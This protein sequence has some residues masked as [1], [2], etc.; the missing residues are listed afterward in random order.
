MLVCTENTGQYTFPFGI[1]KPYNASCDSRTPKKSKI[2]KCKKEKNDKIDA[3]CITIYVSRTQDK[4]Q[5]YKRLTKYITLKS[6]YNLYVPQYK[7]QMK[8]QKNCP[9]PNMNAR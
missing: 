6:E 7:G 4:P 1:Y 3:K 9:K 5:Y 8:D 2:F